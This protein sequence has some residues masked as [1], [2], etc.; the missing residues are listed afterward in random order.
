MQKRVVISV[1][2]VILALAVISAFWISNSTNSSFTGQVF[3]TSSDVNG[4]HICTDSDGG[5]DY[6]VK[7]TVVRDNP[8]SDTVKEDGCVD[9]L[10][11]T[12]F[13]CKE[14]GKFG[15]ISHNCDS[16]YVCDQGA[17]I[18]ESCPNVVDQVCGSD[19][20]TYDSPCLAKQAQ[21]KYTD[22]AC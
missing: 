1:V 22:G 3:A 13:F 18:P 8:G 5:L 15:A 17:C 14:N 11:V 21:V 10:R 6:S 20:N 9:R 16:G 19:G 7:S 2:V 12:E 4:Q